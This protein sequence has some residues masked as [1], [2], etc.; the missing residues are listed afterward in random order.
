MPWDYIVIRTLVGP[1]L[2]LPLAGVCLRA[3]LAS[4]S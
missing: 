2:F 4:H 1:T 3:D